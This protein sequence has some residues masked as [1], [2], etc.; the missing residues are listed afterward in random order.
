LHEGVG[1]GHAAPRRTGGLSLG[2]K[3]SGVLQ[4]RDGNSWPVHMGDLTAQEPGSRSFCG[5]THDR[6]ATP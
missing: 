6:I 1:H 5:D 2:E 4:D 3:M